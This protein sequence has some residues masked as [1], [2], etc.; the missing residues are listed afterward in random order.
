MLVNKIFLH[1]SSFSTQ[2]T[3]LIKREYFLS[4]VNDRESIVATEANNGT[5]C[6]QKRI[7]K[8]PLYR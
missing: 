2:L 1:I 3:E 6:I 8:F 4:E 5:Y 7:E